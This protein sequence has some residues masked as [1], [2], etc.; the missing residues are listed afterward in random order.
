MENKKEKEKEKEREGQ[1]KY[2][3]SFTKTKILQKRRNMDMGIKG[4]H[5]QDLDFFFLSFQT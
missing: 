4:F 3:I 2:P 1:K 5:T